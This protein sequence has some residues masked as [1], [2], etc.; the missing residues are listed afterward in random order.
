MKLASLPPRTRKRLVT[1]GECYHLDTI[2]V[3]TVAVDLLHIALFGPAP[4]DNKTRVLGQR[5]RME[6]PVPIGDIVHE[7]LR[8][9][10]TD[11]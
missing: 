6:R 9:A 5:A 2:G 8:R 3:L 1:I 11:H 10:K 4:A 7:A